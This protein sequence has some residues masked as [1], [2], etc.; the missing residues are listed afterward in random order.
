M[1]LQKELIV[2][3]G[4]NLQ[5]RLN[6]SLLSG[7]SVEIQI[8]WAYTFEEKYVRRMGHYGNHNWFIAYWYPQVAVYDDIDGWDRNHYT[9]TQEMYNDF[10]DYNVKITVPDSFAVWATG[11][12]E[13]AQ[14]VL[15]PSIYEEFKR[16]A[17]T[18]ETIKIAR[19]EDYEKK[20]VVKAEGPNTWSFK[21]NHVPDFA[22]SVSSSLSWDASSVEVE[23]GRRVLV[24]AVY[25]EENRFYDECVQ[26]ARK[27]LIDMSSKLPGVPYPYSEMNIFNGGRSGGG[28]EFPM[29][30]NDGAVRNRADL[31]DLTYHEI[32]HTYFPFYMGINERKYGWMDEGWA[33]ILPHDLIRTEESKSGE[34]MMS[35]SLSYS[36][37][38]GTEDDVALM[39]PSK[40][41]TGRP[42]SMHV[43]S[44]PASAYHILKDMLGE[45]T[46]KK[47]FQTYIEAWNGKHPLPYDFFFTFNKASGQNLD[48]FWKAW[49]FELGTPDLAI[50]EAVVKG[51]KVMVKVEKVG[52]Y[53]VPI[54]LTMTLEDGTKEEIH[55][56]ASVWANGETEFVIKTKVSQPVLSMQLGRPDFPDA[57]RGNDT[58]T[59]SSP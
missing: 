25:L 54:H 47:A 12:L 13:N 19:A 37:F 40:F 16:A 27:C 33:S 52:N 43:Y 7:K 44:K 41:L 21:A 15:Q 50:K 26:I 4:T 24:N 9:G 57:N 58:W 48:W 34:P 23:P 59:A 31:I 1:A 38:A 6:E 30:V 11:T 22:F 42:Y 35:Y 3:Q 39:T 46:F 28:M 55:H 51:K 49:F 36:R 29:I 5:A 2:V 14:E 18:D 17:S 10:S 45:E 20:Q 53:P 8:E 56:T 32:V